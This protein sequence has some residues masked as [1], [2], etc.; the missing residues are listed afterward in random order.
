MRGA[1]DIWAEPG[2]EMGSFAV[3]MVLMLSTCGTSVIG[4]TVA[5]ECT[6]RE[7]SVVILQVSINLK[8]GAAS[9]ARNLPRAA[10]AYNFGCYA[11]GIAVVITR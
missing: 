9:P 8:A 1:T 6:T 5:A 10:F 11:S 7:K 4:R 3:L 2:L